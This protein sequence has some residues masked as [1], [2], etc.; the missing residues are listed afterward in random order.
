MSSFQ[1]TDSQLVLDARLPSLI[2]STITWQR[3]VSLRRKRREHAQR[4][5]RRSQSV[6]SAD[7]EVAVPSNGGVA[8]QL[9]EE[10]ANTASHA[11]GVAFSVLAS[12]P[13]MVFA[14]STGSVFH[15]IACAVYGATALTLYTASTLYHAAVDDRL[16]RKLQRFDHVGIYLF[17]AGSYTPFLLTALRGPLGWTLL[18]A[19]WAMAAVGIWVKCTSTKPF[20]T[21][22]AVPYVAMGW[23]V[24]FAIKPLMASIPFDALVW[25]VAGGLFYTAGVYFY[26]RDR[27]PYNHFIWHLFVLAGS[28]CHFLSITATITATA[29]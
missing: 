1:M 21:M 23:L 14:G 2:E 11:L 19:I 26:V 9:T 22:S 12:I 15:I 4:P 6:V 25:L 20:T 27:K 7:V 8:I 3:E 18:T 17:I 16:K 10:I 24:V 28:V 29:P 13:L 5:V